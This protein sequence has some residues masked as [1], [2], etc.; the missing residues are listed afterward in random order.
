MVRAVRSTRG[1]L[2]IVGGIGGIVFVL[3]ASLIGDLIRLADS[4]TLLA[5]C[6]AAILLSV[7]R[8]SLERHQS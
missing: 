7:A 6:C 4:A 5:V 3:V 8:G 1:A 2:G